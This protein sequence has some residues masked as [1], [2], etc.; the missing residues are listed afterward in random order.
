M[1]EAANCW[2]VPCAIPHSCP[3]AFFPS[4]I[5][6]RTAP[7]HMHYFPGAHHSAGIHPLSGGRE[8]LA[9]HRGT[10]GRRDLQGRA[11]TPHERANRSR[12]DMRGR[13]AK[14]LSL[15]Q[16]DEMA[17]RETWPTVETRRR[18]HEDVS[19]SVRF[20]SSAA[21]PLKLPPLVMRNSTAAQ[22]L[23]V[24]TIIAM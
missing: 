5:F 14:G 12:I 13:L 24:S 11:E 22:H 19:D 4:A 8:D 21:P 10:S 2:L 23:S 1:A 17:R 7:A 3:K 9:S 18:Y 16:R 15:V 6:E 20:Q